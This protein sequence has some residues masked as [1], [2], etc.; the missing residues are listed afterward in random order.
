M[1]D[2]IDLRGAGIDQRTIEVQSQARS[3]LSII[4]QPYGVA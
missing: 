2:D 4:R 1:G 3:D